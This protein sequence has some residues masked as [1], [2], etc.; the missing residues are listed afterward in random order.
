MEDVY[1]MTEPTESPEQPVEGAEST[2]NVDLS[3]IT[4]ALTAEFDKRF[5]GLQGLM[6]RRNSEFQ[7][8]LDD[9]KTADLTPEEQEQYRANEAQAKLNQLQR[10]NEL[11][12]MRK[13]FPEEV[14]L[15]DSFFE[16]SSLQEQLALIASFRKVKAEADPSEEGEPEEQP[17]PVER[18]NPPRRSEVSL[19]DIARGMTGELADKLLDQ[20][21]QPGALRKLRG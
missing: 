16:K 11:L 7:K 2:P 8:A 3:A 17:T 1:T 4:S 20:S 18:N 5:S 14:D 13:E 15:L 19:A 21:N 6:D 12:R 10:E 9:L